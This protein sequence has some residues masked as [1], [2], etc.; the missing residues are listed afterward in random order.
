MNGVTILSENFICKGY[1]KW[2]LLLFIFIFIISVSLLAI[3]LEEKNKGVFI[4]GLI[5]VVSSVLILSYGYRVSSQLS[6][7]K[8]YK[9]T[10]SDDVNINEFNQKYDIISQNG[11]IY[12][13][14][15]KGEK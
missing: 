3:S 5:M 13:I 11:E 1:P 6:N 8:E 2:C 4:V 14:R 12:T 9:I 15:L 7:T 10:I